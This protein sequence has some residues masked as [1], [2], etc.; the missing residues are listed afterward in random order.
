MVTGAGD[1]IGK[2]L[3]VKLAQAGM[4][5][6]IQD[7]R[8]EAA[9]AVAEEIGGGAFPLVFDVSDPDQC[10]DGAQK[11]AQRNEPLCLLWANAGV[12]VG[13]A[14]T[15]APRKTIEWGISVNIAGPIWTVQAFRPLMQPEA[16]PAHIGF[17]SSVAALAAPEG[18]FPFY[19]M[20]K[21]GSFAVAEA[22]RG[23]VSRDGIGATI[24]C[25]GLLNTDIW[26]GARARPERFGGESRMDPSIAAH[27]RKAPAPDVMWPH[28][29]RVVSEGGGYLVCA[30][31]TDSLQRFNA[32]AGEIGNAFVQ[33]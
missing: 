11:L 6:C 13:A 23:E 31:E 2:M 3:A 33:L 24:L 9:R 21:H 12:G 18:D 26:D 15:R 4:T 7:I 1:G 10:F 16:G 19:A 20:T 29:E 14:V 27:W 17:T 30:T 22:I 32:R 5:V 28:I 8:E 25:P